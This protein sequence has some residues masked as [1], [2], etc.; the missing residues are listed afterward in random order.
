MECSERASPLLLWDSELSSLVNAAAAHSTFGSV[1]C[2]LQFVWLAPEASWVAFW[3]LHLIWSIFLRLFGM[4]LPF[5]DRKFGASIVSLDIWLGPLT[6][7][8]PQYCSS[9]R[10]A[11]N[12]KR[13]TKR[14]VGLASLLRRLLTGFQIC[15]CR[16]STCTLNGWLQLTFMLRAWYQRHEPWRI[17]KK[18][19]TLAFACKRAI[20]NVHSVDP[21]THLPSMIDPLLWTEFACRLLSH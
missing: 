7:W 10:A 15:R 6:E 4:V 5:H 17:L 3:I 18:C 2:L 8:T 16:F 11:E 13:G 12:P 21:T 9:S 19:F 1:A 20:L 14:G